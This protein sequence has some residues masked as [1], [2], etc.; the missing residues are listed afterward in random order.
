[1]RSRAFRRHHHDRMLNK[2][3]DFDMY[4]NDFWSEEE[5]LQ[6]QRKMAETRKPCSCHMCGNPRKVFKEKTL[7]EKKFDEYEIE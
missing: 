7:Q 4:Q 3:K 6:H 2:V 5:K 1:M